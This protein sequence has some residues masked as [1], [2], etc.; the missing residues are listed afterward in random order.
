MGHPMNTTGMLRFLVTAAL[1]LV[2]T[3]LAWGL[4]R[5]YMASPWTRD[6]RLRAQVVRIAPDVSGLVRD[7]RVKDNQH[8]RRG[9]VLFVI[10]EVRFTAAARRADAEVERARAGVQ[11]ADAAVTA[12]LA[13]QRMRRDQARRRHGLGAEVVSA[14][15]L[16]D[17][18][19]QAAQADAAVEGAR[20]DAK[21]SAAALDVALAQQHTAAIDVERSVVRAPADGDITNLDL[22]PGDYA[23]A[24]T[25][26]M[27]LVESGTLWVYGYFEETKLTDLRPGQPVR[28]ELLSGRVTLGGHVDSIANGITDRDNPSAG[29]MLADVNPVFTWIRLAQRVPVRIAIDHVPPG[30]NI[31]AGMTA[32]V[33]VNTAGR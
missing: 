12:R 2:A 16:S 14:E 18:G 4:W 10:D 22:Y 23:I 32:T 11:V 7:V 1:V 9:D 20:A 5:D 28:V 3:A 17:L 27:S 15:S 8:V 19:S 26:R 13:E 29:G 21:A 24:G 25:P 31:A 6:G 30:A 33:I